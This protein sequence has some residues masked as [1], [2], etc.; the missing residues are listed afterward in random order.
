MQSISVAVF[1]ICSIAVPRKT[2]ELALLILAVCFAFALPCDA[3]EMK[4]VATNTKP[5]VGPSARTTLAMN[6]NE[7][8]SHRF[9]T[10]RSFFFLAPI[11][12][13]AAIANAAAA[14]AETTTGGG[15]DTN[16][17]AND[18]SQRG[19]EASKPQQQRP[20]VS[21]AYPR[22]E[23][24]NSIVASRDTNISP[25]EVYETILRLRKERPGESGVTASGSVPPGRPRALDVGAGAGVSTQVI[26]DQLGYVDIDAIDWSGE[27]WRINV[28]E[29]GYCPPT[30]NFYELDDERFVE[31]VWKEEHLEKYDIIAFNFAVNRQ[32]ALY[33]C[34][35][36]LKPD[37]LLL[38]PVNAQT[39][40]WLKQTYQLLNANGEVVWSTIDV[41]AWSVQFQPD[42]TQDTCQGIWCSPFN[43]F[44]KMRR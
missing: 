22:K 6:T 42:V 18:P 9:P 1:A 35:N 5:P 24:T 32:K 11:L 7:N 12:P 8:T 30:V 39:D 23:L 26:Y 33:F 16:Q 15:I 27:A 19:N 43:G 25:A 41:G 31:T 14:M 2:H 17:S 4:A 28:V 29:G 40:Y 3:W 37:G 44:Q 20:F 10:R 21:A 13:S 36:L 34:R 38:A